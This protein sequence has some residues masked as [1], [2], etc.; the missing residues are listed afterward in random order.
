[1]KK[2]TISIL[3]AI[4][5]KIKKI[6]DSDEV[7]SDNEISKEF[8][9]IDHTEGDQPTKKK[10]QNIDDLDNSKA[11]DLELETNI[12]DI[13]SNSKSGANQPAEANADSAVQDDE[14]YQPI[15]DGDDFDLSFENNELEDEG[16]IDLGDIDSDEQS[17]DLD[18]EVKNDSDYTV[19]EASTQE[20]ESIPDFD[21]GY[22][23]DDFMDFEDPTNPVAKA[24]DAIF[25]KDLLA[26]ASN[27]EL[28]KNEISGD[29]LRVSD[30]LETQIDNSLDDN[31]LDNEF[32]HKNDAQGD[33][34]VQNNVPQQSQ[35]QSP[36]IT[37]AQNDDALNM[38]E[39]SD[40]ELE[41]LSESEFT[42]DEGDQKKQSGLFTKSLSDIIA[43]EKLEK[44]Q[45]P[46]PE[47]GG[48]DE[49]FLD[50]DIDYGADKANYSAENA[51]DQD[52]AAKD[53]LGPD[54]GQDTVEEGTDKVVFADGNEGSDVDVEQKMNDFLGDEKV[55][56]ENKVTDPINN[57]EDELFTQDDSLSDTADYSAEDGL[58]NDEDVLDGFNELNLDDAPEQKE[59]E[60]TKNDFN[61]T[62]NDL[63]GDDHVVVPAFNNNEQY[64]SSDVDHDI[65]V[66][67]EISSK[68]AQSIQ[69]LSDAKNMVSKVGQYVEGDMLSHVA[70]ELMKPKLEN[71]FNENLPKLVENVV[72]EE[73]KKIISDNNKA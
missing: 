32:F 40:D 4:K 60:V 9:Y 29:E 19:D 45:D 25:D 61:V 2:N 8:E 42:V 36:E 65:V 68:V 22:V 17:G 41:I 35:E 55:G 37:N 30:D 7:G 39:I 20:V 72:R 43:E 69:G 54:E 38:D 59:V 56:D 13:L 31:D 33:S 66:N 44:L 63:L 64:N 26:S 47:Q 71:W 11:S 21:L 67:S 1:M 53:D 49:N 52:I 34:K 15:A 27:E 57:A 16:S 10:S 3:E 51:A 73:I 5:R 48:V 46:T 24:E 28:P 62:Q 23:E 14:N 18:E 6:D 12:E 70:F 58:R 50:S